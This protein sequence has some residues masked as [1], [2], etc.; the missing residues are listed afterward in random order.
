MA[1]AAAVRAAR[2]TCAVEMKAS[3]R[4][5][6]RATSGNTTEGASATTAVTTSRCGGT[7][8]GTTVVAADGVMSAAAVRGNDNGGGMQQRERDRGYDDQWQ[9]DGYGVPRHEYRGNGGMS[10]TVET[11]GYARIGFSASGSSTGQPG[12]DK[13]EEGRKRQVEERGRAAAAKAEAEREREERGRK[14][15]K[16]RE[17]AAA[18]AAKEKRKHG[19]KDETS[20]DF[21]KACMER[22]R[23]AYWFTKAL[24]GKSKGENGAPLPHAVEEVWGPL[25]PA[26]MDHEDILEIMHHYLT[27]D[28]DFKH[29]EALHARIQEYMLLGGGRLF[30]RKLSSDAGEITEFLNEKGSGGIRGMGKMDVAVK[31]LV[32]CAKRKRW[33][34][35]LVKCKVDEEIKLVKPGGW[36]GKLAELLAEDAKKIELIDRA[37][38]ASSTFE[39]VRAA[40]DVH[41]KKPGGQPL[42]SLGPRA[43]RNLATFKG[44]MSHEMK[45]KYPKSR[46]A[47]QV[48]EVADRKGWLLSLARYAAD[49]KKLDEDEVYD[50]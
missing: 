29:V 39:E 43:D 23:L 18:K 19:V 44:Y 8:C 13:A 28:A 47:V 22:A 40:F 5:D 17:K 46:Y 45:A 7:T 3:V 24:A 16:E 1:G 27:A 11:Q 35:G 15:E 12:V 41:T 4:R 10:F 48:L 9:C 2:D 31:R 30:G 33:L 26:D 6:A 37:A 38:A 49:Q 32:E 42:W 25:F 50:E 36:P 20:E 14:A 21:P 34:V